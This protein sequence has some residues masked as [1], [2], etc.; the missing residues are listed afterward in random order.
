MKFDTTFFIQQM[1]WYSKQSSISANLSQLLSI[2]N[3]IQH[4]GNNVTK[5]DVQM[6]LEP[7]GFSEKDIE[8]LLTCSLQNKTWSFLLILIISV[9]IILRQLYSYF[10]E[11]PDGITYIDIDRVIFNQYRVV[12]RVSRI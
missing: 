4:H 10:S 2:R 3:K 1:M 6:T 8:M 7:F 5:L 12:F 11:R 9:V